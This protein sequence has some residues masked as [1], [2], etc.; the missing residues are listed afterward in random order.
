MPSSRHLQRTETSSDEI[1]DE[2]ERLIGQLL[3]PSAG[4]RLVNW[5]QNNLARWT[6]QHFQNQAAREAEQQARRPQ[7]Q[8]TAP[9]YNLVTVLAD[10]TAANGPEDEDQEV[11]VVSPSPTTTRT[12]HNY[13][14]YMA[15]RD[16]DWRARAE[17]MTGA[18]FREMVAA[19]SEDRARWGTDLW[20]TT[21]EDS[22]DDAVE[23]RQ[24]F[25]D[26]SS[27]GSLFVE[28]VIRLFGLLVARFVWTQNWG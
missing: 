26:S 4:E 1:S 11:T 28:V 2:N 19:N 18:R 20:G 8:E 15:Q 5:Q 13:Q 3:G 14:E 12:A 17:A 6:D 21:A 16:D 25:D 10:A 7:E 27:D 9:I 23:G 24:E 22:N